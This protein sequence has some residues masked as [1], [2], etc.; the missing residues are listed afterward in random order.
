MNTSNS[1]IFLSRAQ[2]AEL[3]GTPRRQRQIQW[4][5]Q[6]NFRFWVTVTG[7]PIIPVTAIA[8]S[9]P[10]EEKIDTAIW[11]PDVLKR[12]GRSHG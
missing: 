4:L 8:P 12:S 10:V 5:R 1:Q 6:N 7:D 11:Q 3:T 9:T 2:T